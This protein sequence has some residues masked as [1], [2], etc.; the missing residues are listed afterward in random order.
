MLR[1]IQQLTQ[2]YLLSQ[3]DVPIHE[4]R[5]PISQ[6]S[7]QRPCPLALMRLTRGWRIGVIG[8]GD[9]TPVCAALRWINEFDVSDAPE[10]NTVAVGAAV[11]VTAVVVGAT[12]A[13]LPPSCTS[14]VV[15]GDAYQHCGPNWYQPQY[16][17]TQEYSTSS[18]P[19]GDASAAMRGDEL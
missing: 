13:S 11:G 17:G 2:R 8:G 12:V 10:G 5:Y 19:R 6:L 7:C 4:Q 15:N 16:V 18:P 9:S 14:A 1:R 3:S